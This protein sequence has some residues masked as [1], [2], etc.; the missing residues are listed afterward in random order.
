[1]TQTEMVASDLSAKIQR[2]VAQEYSWPDVTHGTRRR[3]LDPHRFTPS[4]A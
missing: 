3:Q 4:P 1:M 2:A